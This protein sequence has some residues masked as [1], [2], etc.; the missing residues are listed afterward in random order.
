MSLFESISLLQPRTLLLG[1]TS[2]ESNRDTFEQGYI[3]DVKAKPA[4]PH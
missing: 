4:K 1:G 3:A 2:R